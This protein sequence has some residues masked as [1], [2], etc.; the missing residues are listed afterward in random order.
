LSSGFIEPT[1]GVSGGGAFDMSGNLIGII[2]AEDNNKPGRFLVI[3]INEI[4][5]AL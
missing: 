5:E 2:V 4:R 3:P 1:K